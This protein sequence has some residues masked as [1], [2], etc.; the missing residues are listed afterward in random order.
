MQAW[1]VYR[2]LEGRQKELPYSQIV[3]V[4]HASLTRKLQSTLIWLDR[5]VS[6]SDDFGIWVDCAI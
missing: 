1:K 4:R 5:V 6:T 2:D 3:Q